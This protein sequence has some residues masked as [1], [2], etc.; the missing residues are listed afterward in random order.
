VPGIDRLDDLASRRDDLLY[1]VSGLE[2]EI[3]DEAEEER[4]GHRHGEQVFL[5]A[6]GNADTL[7]GHVLG[8]QHDRGRIRWVFGQVDVGEAELERE[9][10]RDLLLGREIHPDEDDADTFPRTLVFRKR[11]LEVSFRDE[12]GLDQ[13]LTDLLSHSRYPL[14]WRELQ[15]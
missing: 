9:R 5:E 6:Y 8:D 7:G 12:A 15:F 10:L 13:A 4:I 3:L 2:L 11:G 14:S 1:A